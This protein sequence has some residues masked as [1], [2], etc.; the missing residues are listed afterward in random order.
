MGSAAGGRQY[1]IGYSDS[2]SD[3]HGKS[4][5]ASAGGAWGRE[6]IDKHPGV[7]GYLKSAYR[8][9]ARDKGQYY[10][11]QL[12]LELDEKL[13][14]PG[15]GSAAVSDDG[16]C[17]LA[18]KRAATC[19]RF[20][21]KALSKRD[22]FSVAGDLADYCA[23]YGVDFPS[24][25]K[26]GDNSETAA[27]KSVIAFER[28]ADPRWWR[29]QFRVICQRRVESVVRELGFVHAGKSPYV[30]NWALKR[31]QGAQIR[32]NDILASLEAVNE[33]GEAVPLSECAEKSISNPSHR[34]DEL[35]VRSKGHDQIAAGLGLTGLFFTLTCPSKYHAQLTAGRRNPKFAGASPR[36]GMG[37]LNKTWELIRSAWDKKGI[38]AF[39]LRVVEPHHDGT[40][41]FH[42]WLF[43]PCELVELACDIFGRYALA[44]DGDEPGAKEYRWKVEK[45]DPAKG[46]ATGYILKYITKNLTG[47]G[48][49][50]DYEAEIEAE[51][52]ATRA[53]AWASIWGI[54]QFQQIGSVSV[55]VWRELRRRHGL[56][57]EMTPET[58]REIGEAADS[59]DWALF[60]TLMGGPFVRRD[61]QALRPAYF[62]SEALCTKYGAELRRLMGVW[63]KPVVRA[64][65]RCLVPTRDH[66]W[67]IKART[68]VRDQEAAQPPP[69]D[70]CQ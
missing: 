48:V 47:K 28:V 36:D 24:N 18:E 34:A 64:I 17:N 58:A 50:F 57:D 2:E 67:S 41:H 29:R 3:S 4:V 44:V 46:T 49:G 56:F 23:R 12:L 59:G 16:I 55:T 37:H 15:V 68:I 33:E 32:N 61:D 25:I 26:R 27:K 63:L 60:C 43:L 5:W 14:L 66:V 13:K 52:G 39:G 38:K 42:F 21:K 53:R 19:E 54:R 65:G 7:S 30:S 1:E 8:R 10:A 11:N 70:L 31:W 62:E 20:F 22:V 35:I 9:R 40:P 69:L 45:I 51:D 6:I